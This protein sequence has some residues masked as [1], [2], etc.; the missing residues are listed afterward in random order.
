[1]APELPELFEEPPEDLLLLAE[2]REPPPE[3]PL[4]P[5]EERELPPEDRLLPAVERDLLPDD[6]ELPTERDRG[7]ECRPLLPLTELGEREVDPRTLDD[8]DGE[9]LGRL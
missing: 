4:L 1:L 6:C 9:V 3:D 8:P 5:A 7:A 2:G